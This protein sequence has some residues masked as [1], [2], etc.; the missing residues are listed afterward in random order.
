MVSPR[1]EAR[2]AAFT[3]FAFSST[4]TF[5]IPLMAALRMSSV[6]HSVM[7]PV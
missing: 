6:F 4:T 2:L 3:R 1:A 5:K 7:C